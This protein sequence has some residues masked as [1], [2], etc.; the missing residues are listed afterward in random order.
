[1][2]KKQNLELSRVNINLPDT[3]IEKVKNYANDLGINVTS[4]YIV[5]LNRALEQNDAMI[6]LPALLNI[7]STLNVN[8]KQLEEAQNLLKD[9]SNQK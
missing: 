5:L 2:A 9:N 8:A 4:A 7:L 1:M 3:L 6:Q